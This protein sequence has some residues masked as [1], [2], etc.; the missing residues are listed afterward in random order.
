MFTLKSHTVALK[1]SDGTRF[2]LYLAPGGAVCLERVRR[3][4]RRDSNS[5]HQFDMQD[6]IEAISLLH[7]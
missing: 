1:T 7:T 2:F 4:G 5:I 6:L 3:S